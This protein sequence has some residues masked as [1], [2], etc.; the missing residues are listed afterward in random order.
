[1]WET[2]VRSLG[3]ED[4]LEKGKATHCSILAW[5]I[6][7]TVHGVAKNQTLTERLF[8]LERL[9][10][11]FF[12]STFLTGTQAN[13]EFLQHVIHSALSTT[14]ITLHEKNQENV[15]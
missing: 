12:T 13:L 7:W 8:T 15:T 5:R 9:P 1:M 11:S 6:P 10:L 14:V 3:W 2:W 4:P